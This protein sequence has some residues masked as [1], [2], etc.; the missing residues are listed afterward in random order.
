MG[1][2]THQDERSDETL[3][4]RPHH[5]LLQAQR[6]HHRSRRRER[7]C[8][9]RRPRSGPLPRGPDGSATARHCAGFRHTARHAGPG[10]HLSRSDCAGT[11]HARREALLRATLCQRYGPF[12][13]R[14]A[15]QQHRP[16]PARRSCGHE[17]RRPHD[18]GRLRRGRRRGGHAQ[19]HD[20]GLR[21]GCRHGGLPVPAPHARPEA[22][23]PELP[24]YPAG[25]LAGGTPQR[26]RVPCQPALQ[27]K[28]G[29]IERRH[30]RPG[31]KRPAVPPIR[32]FGHARTGLRGAPRRLRALRHPGRHLG[33]RHDARVQG[34][35]HGRV[36][37]HRVAGR[38]QRGRHGQDHVG[39]RLVHGVPLVLRALCD[40]GVA[41][42]QALQRRTEGPGLLGAHQTPAQAAH[43][44]GRGDRARPACT[45]RAP[46][47]RRRVCL[48]R[49]GRVYP[50]RR[51]PRRGARANRGRHGT[52]RGRQVRPW[53]DVPVRAALRGQHLPRRN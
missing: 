5:N 47:A 3:P 11:G 41:L 9:Q 15:V 35:L 13:A 10:G 30:D 23:A 28:R 21:H 50:A 36:R 22:C 24:L 19:G 49:P 32:A 42:R 26:A 38:A 2:S 33:K 14:H 12:H 39:H 20:G 7:H 31:G 6:P 40:Q 18:Q 4:T 1:H 52:S 45:P 25:L 53:Q 48:W 44:V 46:P 37:P 8:V 16:H 17:C 43:R 51:E 29:Q 34:R 27:G